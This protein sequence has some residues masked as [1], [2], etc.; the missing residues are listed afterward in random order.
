MGKK[1]KGYR[2]EEEEEPVKKKNMITEEQLM[3]K[4]H[5]DRTEFIPLLPTESLYFPFQYEKEGE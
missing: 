2:R 3:D 4:S 5:M 1:G